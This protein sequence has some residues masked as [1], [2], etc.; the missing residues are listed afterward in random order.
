MMCHFIH[1]AYS[2]N[3]PGTGT[4]APCSSCVPTGWTLDSGSPDISDAAGWGYSLLGTG[5]T[6]WSKTIPAIPNGETRFMSAHSTEVASMMIRGLTPGTTYSLVF[7]YMTAT[8]SNPQLGGYGGTL[9]PSVRYSIDGGPKIVRNIAADATWYKEDIVFTASSDSTQFTFYGGGHDG[10]FPG[11]GTTEGD[12]VNISFAPSSVIVSGS[13]PPPQPP[14]ACAST[15][16]VNSATICSGQIAVLTASGAVTY[17]WSNGDLT[18]STTVSPTHTTTY[19]VAGSDASGCSGKATSTVKVL[20][21]PKAEFDFT[22]K[23][24]GLLNQTITFRDGSSEDVNYWNWNFGDGDSLAPD[25]KNPVHTYSGKEAIY[26]VTLNVSNG[27]CANSTSHTVTIGPEYAFY[28]PNAFSPNNDEINDVFG[29]K[30]KGILKFQLSVFDRWGNLI[31]KAD[32]INKTWNGRANGGAD[33][34]QQDV[35]VWKADVTDI[36]KKEH[37]YMGT[38]TLVKRE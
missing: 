26:L 14:T 25:T 9:S 29:G 18:A 32:D 12:L 35:Y 30:G 17:A 13:T 8:V 28:I 15:I 7:Y 33:V 24:A 27:A 3:H 20:P 4:I 6:A 11:S 34:A 31:F 37:K 2:Q 21:I 5:Q 38:V 16:T 36:F 1:G 10:V 23:Q 22:P 19:T